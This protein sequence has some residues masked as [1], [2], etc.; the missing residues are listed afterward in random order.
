M[1]R[2]AVIMIT[3]AAGFIGSCLLGY[4]NELGYDQ[5]VIVDEFTDEEKEP[6]Y[7]GKKF[8]AQVEREELFE[9]LKKDPVNIDFVF[10]LG[11]RT[12]TTEFDY[13][14]H[15][16]LNVDYSKKIWNYCAEKNIVADVELIRIQQINEAYERML[17]NDVRY[18]FV[19]DDQ[20]TAV[21]SVSLVGVSPNVDIFPRRLDFGLS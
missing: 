11:A 9:W 16:H 10:H 6:N 8:F 7:T 19:I 15:Q 2:N 12:D 20:G 14:V 4:L 13:A 17:R 1:D 18:R 21:V 5:L 3:G